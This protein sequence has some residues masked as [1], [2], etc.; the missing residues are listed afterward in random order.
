MD[1]REKLFGI[2]RD[3]VLK[4]LVILI[5]VSIL[6]NSLAVIGLLVERNQRQEA[7]RISVQDRTELRAR[8]RAV[9]CLIL[10]VLDP[11]VAQAEQRHDPISPDLPRALDRLREPATVQ[12]APTQVCKPFRPQTRTPE[13][14]KVSIITKYPEA[15]WRPSTI[16]HPRRDATLGVVEHWTAGSEPGDLVT[17][18]GPNVDCHFYVTKAGRV[19]QFLDL[20]SQAWHAFF[21]ANHYCVG[22]E[23]EGRGEP[24]TPAQ[25][26]ATVKL[27]A[28]ICEQTGVPV[29]H[30]DPSGHDTKTFRGL[31][32]HRDLSLGGVRVD[33]NDHTDTVPDNPGWSRFISAVQEAVADP[34][35]KD[36][37]PKVPKAPDY[38]K[39]PY[40]NAFRLAVGGRLYAGPEDAD[41]PILWLLRNGLRDERAAVSFRGPKA[42][43]PQVFR[44]ADLGTDHVLQV[45]RTIYNQH[46]EGK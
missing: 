23:H 31:F 11:L 12:N 14:D 37:D 8:A 25:F 46:M 5:S 21:M 36:P 34:A 29:R 39:F 28:W 9:E 3:T 33:G 4:V 17:L 24:W 6:I 26:D 20:Y 44:A 13:E 45:I 32:G 10:G 41:G 22:I 16:G 35:D 27:N 7:D 18:D 1:P 19:Y 15:S 43:K 40:P 2:S 38:S 30:V 42:S